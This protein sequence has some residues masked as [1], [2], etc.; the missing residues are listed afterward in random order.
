MNSA[1]PNAFFHRFRGANRRTHALQHPASRRNR[2]YQ[3]CG[4][5]RHDWQLGDHCEWSIKTSVLCASN[6]ERHYAAQVWM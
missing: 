4:G 1:Q 6:Q 5:L 3:Q 2:W